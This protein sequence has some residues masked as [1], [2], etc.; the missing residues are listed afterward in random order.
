M[1]FYPITEEEDKQANNLFSYHRP[2]GDQSERYEQ[3]RYEAREFWFFLLKNCPRSAE[4]T[5]ARRALED[6]VMRAN[7]SIAVNEVEG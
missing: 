4:L 6:C 1:T 3:I 2:F 5:L 7:Q